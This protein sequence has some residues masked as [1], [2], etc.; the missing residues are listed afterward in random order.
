MQRVY[1][2]IGCTASGKSSL[3]AALA[4]RHGGQILSVDSMKIYRHMDIGAA[5]PSADILAEIPHHAIDVAD[6]WE[7]CSFTVN[8]YQRVAD[9]AIAEI[10]AAGDVV[11]AVGGTNLY[12]KVLIEGM[13]EGPGGSPE[14]REQLT[15]RA[16]AEGTAALHAELAAVDPAA[17]ER[18]HPNDQ[19]RIIRALEVY[20]LTG[21]PISELQ[22]QWEGGN[23]R[24]DFRLLLLRCEREDA[25]S[26]INARVKRMVDAGLVDEVERLTADPR[27]LNHQAAA[28]LGY[29][30]MLRHFAGEWT[31][32][33]AVE[34]IKI[35][36]RRFAKNQRTWQR[37]FAQ[38]AALD[39]APNVTVDSVA[40]R[41]AELLGLT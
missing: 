8:D 9:A 13:F 1:V 18:I 6:P 7:G 5:K 39:L 38:A 20:R 10:A 30:E 14:L 12:L 29:A 25:N 3:G 27:G 21:T 35:N 2:I 26:R 34:R 36:T 19:R 37:R 28:A 41:A 4:R 40:D 31:L 16:A 33:E 15:G 11:L 22:T 32:D 24:Y 17:A 23:Q